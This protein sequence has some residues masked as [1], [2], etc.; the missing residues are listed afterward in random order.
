MKFLANENIPIELVEEL[1]NL[2]YDI[3]RADNFKK[4]LKDQDVLELAFKER[5]ILITF[6][7]DFGELAVKQKKKVI[8]VILLRI[9]PQS[10]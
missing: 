3:L 6:D 1:K 9:K 4:G 7:K 10:I 2:R 5:R 8:G